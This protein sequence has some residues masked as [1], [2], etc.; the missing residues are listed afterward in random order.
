M[1]C[2]CTTHFS[3]VM[4]ISIFEPIIWGKIETALP[5][6]NVV[7]FLLSKTMRWSQYWYYRLDIMVTIFLYLD[8]P[9]NWIFGIYLF[10][11]DTPNFIFQKVQILTFFKIYVIYKQHDNFTMQTN[12]SC[13][14]KVFWHL[15]K[16]LTD[17][18]VSKL[19]C[20][21]CF[22]LFPFSSP[23]LF[24]QLESLLVFLAS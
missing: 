17:G 2:L 23:L 1:K 11:S 6:Y 10:F 15:Y 13:F 12:F 7:S 8:R 24:L 16:N 22:F 5:C 20:L 19:F 9:W 18:F 4:S 21:L 3:A 14:L